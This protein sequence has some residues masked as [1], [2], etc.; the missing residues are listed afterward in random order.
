MVMQCVYFELLNS[1]IFVPRFTPMNFYNNN[2]FTPT[3]DNNNDGGG[4]KS[5]YALRVRAK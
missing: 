4:D 2:N 1:L 3:D 5:Y